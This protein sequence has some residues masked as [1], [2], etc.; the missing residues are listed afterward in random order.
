[1][2]RAERTKFRVVDAPGAAAIMEPV[3]DDGSAATDPS[4]PRDAPAGRHLGGPA[5]DIDEEQHA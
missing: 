2:S 4:G 3:A 5:I 1:M